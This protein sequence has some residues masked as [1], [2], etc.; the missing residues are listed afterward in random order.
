M[1]GDEGKDGV[2]A[3]LVVSLVAGD[4]DGEVFLGSEPGDGVP[5][6]VAAGVGEGGAVGDDP[7]HG[8]FRLAGGG[9]VELLE[10]LGFDQFG[11][12][13]GEIGGDELGPVSDRAVDDTGGAP[14]A[15]A[16][17]PAG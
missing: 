7:A 2:V 9:S 3:G 8:V 16:G 4:E 6:G 14:G 17:R 15:A 10:R 5:H 13:G 1:V 12:G 11:F